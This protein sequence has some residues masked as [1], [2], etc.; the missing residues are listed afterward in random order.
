MSL[1]HFFLF[2]HVFMHIGS[3]EGVTLLELETVEEEVPPEVHEGPEGEGR[4]QELPGCP[5]HV[6]ASFLKDKPRSI[7][8]L[9]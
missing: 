7:L 6:P 8:S 9:P 1:V 2:I 5:E 3:P 4:V